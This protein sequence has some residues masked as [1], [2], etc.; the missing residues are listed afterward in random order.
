MYDRNIIKLIKCLQFEEQMRSVD[1]IQC[2]LLIVTKDFFAQL[3]RIRPQVS[4][5]IFGKKHLRYFIHSTLT[6]RLGHHESCKW[7]VIH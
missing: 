3:F 2:S 6:P 1:E 4:R 7:P 5:R